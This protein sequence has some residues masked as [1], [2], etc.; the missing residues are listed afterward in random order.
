MAFRIDSGL[1]HGLFADAHEEM[2]QLVERPFG[3]KERGLFR[4]VATADS[5]FRMTPMAARSAIERVSIGRCLPVAKVRTVPTATDAA[6]HPGLFD[7]FADHHAILLELLGQNSVQEGVAA[8]VQRQ[9]E[10]GEN[11]GLFQID[12]MD[13]TGR[14]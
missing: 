7:R 3:I 11:F 2:L 8:A 4:G 14:R 1:M 9:D 10:N 5:A 12:E 13:A 6:R